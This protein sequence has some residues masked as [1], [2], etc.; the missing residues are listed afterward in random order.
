MDGSGSRHLEGDVFLMQKRKKKVDP[1]TPIRPWAAIITWLMLNL[2][3]M[4]FSPIATPHPVL[5][6]EG[7]HREY[8]EMTAPDVL[9]AE[10]PFEI[11][12]QFGTTYSEHSNITASWELW[13]VE[14][15]ERVDSG[16]FD[17]PTT[18]LSGPTRMW[19][20][21][22]NEDCGDYGDTIPPGEYVLEFRFYS[23]NGTRITWDEAGRIV[24]GEFTMRYWIYSPHQTIGYIIAN[25]LGILILVTDQ[26]V[27]RMRRRKRLTKKKLPLHKQ[28]HK[29]EWESLH[30]K[31]EGDGG[32]AVESFQIELGATSESEREEMRKRFEETTEDESE[33]SGI[34]ESEV[35][36]SDDEL[37][38]GSVAGLEGKTK[39]DKDIQTVG[40]LWKRMEDDDEF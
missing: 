27:R 8:Y 11:D 38:Q 9:G 40:D 33:D 19:S 28:R 36:Q 15:K 20:G 30:E 4:G 26:A 14:T 35:T 3:W 31:M 25:V 7:G 23:A 22:L 2:I 5:S 13:E 10:L 17:D 6:E 32:A 34:P 29:E 1:N 12:C 24:D 16:D 37:G 39:V 21:G 18:P